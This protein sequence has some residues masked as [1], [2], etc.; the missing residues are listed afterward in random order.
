M[1]DDGNFSI[2][3]LIPT[4][5]RSA[6]LRRAVASAVGQHGV[7]VKVC[8]FD[9]CSDDDTPEVMGRL[10]QGDARIQYH[11]HPRNLGGFANFDLAMRDVA[12]PYF[13]ILSDDDYL[14][15]GFYQ[16]ALADLAENPRAMFWVGETL[17]VDGLG[18]IWDARIE[19]W[20]RE[21]LFLPPEGLMEMMHGRAPTWTGVVFRHEIFQ[22]IGFLDAETLGPSDLDYMLR[23]ASQPFILRKLPVAVYMLN[24]ESF[25]ATQPLSSFWPGWQKIFANIERNPALDEHTRAAALGAL[26]H[27]AKS[28]LFRRGAN[29]L[30]TGRYDFSREAAGALHLC[31]GMRW[32]AWLLEG[33]AWLCEAMPPVQGVYTKV[34]REW[35][36]RLV[37]SRGDLEARYGHLVQRSG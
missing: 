5:N 10:A 2:S 14:L 31:Y 9:N 15:P 3:A 20:S 8:V 32:R 1:S 6:L 22:R 21:G 18:T 12:T 19:R 4:Y 33:L 11:R 34:Y 26:H 35:E 28:M 29:A 25:S 24:P 17:W 13:S 37:A 7:D 30:V 16:R 23:A 36:K 27:D